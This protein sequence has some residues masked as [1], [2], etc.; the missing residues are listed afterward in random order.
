MKIAIISDIHDN[1]HNLVLFF[2]QVKKYKVEK[3]I[4]LGDFSNN[5]IAKMLASFDVPVIAIWGNND[6]EKTAI[7]RTALSKKSNMTIGFSTYDLLEVDN[8]KIFI[9]HYPLLVKPMAKSR[10][11]DA[12]FYGHDHKRNID[13]IN[14]CIIVNPGEI[15][16]H[17]TSEAHFVIY[18]T[19]TNNARSIKIRGA[20]TTKTKEVNK[21]LKDMKFSFSKSKSHKY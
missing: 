19:K 4:F 6:G 1:F 20:I 17:K 13:K 11:F 8:R 10:E 7:T 9:T 14:D 2:K 16:A 21:Y 3:I 15:S 5:G 12:V 18:N